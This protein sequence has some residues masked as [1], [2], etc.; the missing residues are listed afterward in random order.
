MTILNNRIAA[1]DPVAPLNPFLPL[2]TSPTTNLVWLV[3]K[4][5]SAAYDLFHL[6][7]YSLLLY[8]WQ[9]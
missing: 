8:Q 6:A 4:C 2:N 5:C 1:F 3:M 9:Y 7:Y